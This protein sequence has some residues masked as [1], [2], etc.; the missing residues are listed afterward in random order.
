[1]F[2]DAYGKIITNNFEK[3]RVQKERNKKIKAENSNLQKAT[4]TSVE[5]CTNGG[6]EQTENINGSNF[7]KDFL[8]NIG[9]PPGP[10]QCRSI[11]QSGVNSIPQYNPT[12]SQIMATSVPSNLIDRYMGDIKAFDQY[13]L[14][15][16]YEN[17][18]TYGAIVQGKRFKTN[19][20]HFLKFNYKAILQSVYNNSHQD[21]QAFFKARI[22]NKNKV[23]VSEFCLVGDEKNCIF[24]KV[25][26]GGSWY[27]TLYTANWQSG[28][29]DI[30][31][32]PNN[33]EFT[34]EFMASRC[35]L[36]GHFGYA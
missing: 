9:D 31:S 25:S 36:G 20:E 35:G 2:E 15:I 24:T 16:N 26:D 5:M 34:V 11:S 23:V 27:V 28:I 3:L 19:N 33:E 13:A 21:N 29:L 30:S 32:I 7:I 4:L 1:M 22:L 18:G 10:T 14:K 12:Q 8:Y 17:S 6:F